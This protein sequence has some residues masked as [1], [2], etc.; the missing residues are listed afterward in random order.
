MNDETAALQ[1]QVERAVVEAGWGRVAGWHNQSMEIRSERQLSPVADQVSALIAVTRP[2]LVGLL[3]SIGD[4][5]LVAHGGRE[6]IRLGDLGRVRKQSDGDLGV[7]FEYAVH[8]AVLREEPA[9]ME[10]ISTALARVRIKES[11]PS[12]ILFAIEKS[13][14][15]QLIETRRELITSESRVLS[16]NR[17]QPIKLQSHMNRIAAAFHRPATRP[18]LPRSIQGLW[19][20]DLF[21]GSTTREHW[22]GASVKINPSRLEGAAGLRIAIV[23]ASAGTSDSVRLD[24]H[25]NLVVCPVPHDYSFMQTFYEA[26][27]IIQALVARD[28][29][30]PSDSDLPHPAHREVARVYVERRDH[31]VSDV[32]DSVGLFAQPY[33]LETSPEDVTVS[34]FD[35]SQGSATSTA[36]TPIPLTT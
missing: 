23:P 1:E 25:K 2:I 7:A 28:F 18:Q 12:S 20:A 27:R 17:G 3:H 35:T 22:V 19:K 33:L 16:G 24:E 34:L 36:V 31:K 4:E 29:R 14:S 15:K 6:G 32:L 5:Y 21:L 11:D 10:R 8:E 13:G 30:M 26:M 9:I